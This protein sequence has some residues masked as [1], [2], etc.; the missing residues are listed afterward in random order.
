MA[1]EF[2]PIVPTTLVAGGF[3]LDQLLADPAQSFHAALVRHMHEADAVLI[4]G[5]GFGDAHVNRALRNRFAL[6][7]F[8]PAGRPPAVVLTN[9]A[10]AHGS[11]AGRQGH[12][13][14]AWELTHTLNCRFQAS[15]MQ[16][17]NSLT[18]A[19][20]VENGTLETDMNG[21]VA[22]WHSGFAEALGSIDRVISWLRR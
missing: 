9:T 19:P 17:G 3:K 1:S 4:A 22:V 7:P 14:W 13:F 2:R 11:V 12:E 16:A 8:K 21:R 15:A 20:Y 10:P 5:Y 18:A 6:S